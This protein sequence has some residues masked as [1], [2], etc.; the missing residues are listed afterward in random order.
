MNFRLTWVW[1]VWFAGVCF[2]SF[3]LAGIF[4]RNLFSVTFDKR[5][6]EEAVQLVRF[7]APALTKGLLRNPDVITFD[8]YNVVQDLSKDERIAQVVYLNKAG[9]VRWHKNPELITLDFPTYEQ[10]V[11]LTSTAIY[12]AKATLT[13]KIFEVAGQPY[14]EV[15]VPFLSGRKEFVGMISLLVSRESVN[16]T[17]RWGMNKYKLGA[18]VVALLLGGPLYFFLYQFVLRPLEAMQDAVD[19]LSLK[20]LEWRAS[21]R[22][23]EFGDLGGAFE[24]FLEKVKAELSALRSREVARAGAERQW[25]SAIFQVMAQD[26]QAIVVDEDNNVLFTNIALSGPVPERM[27]LLDVVDSQQQDLLRLVGVALE[28]PNELVQGDTLFHSRECHVR[29]VHLGDEAGMR[30]TLIFFE[31]KREETEFAHS[32]A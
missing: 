13:T 32:R 11:G 27:H 31:P 26:R 1:L 21:V 3:A 4:F 16:A 14:Y 7:H 19:G 9:R 25:W 23:D 28:R 20:N 12:E 22:K 6:Q 8:E 10:K 24:Q 5:L 29:I 15:A 18:L 2:Y 30:R 17:V